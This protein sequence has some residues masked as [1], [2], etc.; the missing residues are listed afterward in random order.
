MGRTNNPKKFD[1]QNRNREKRYKLSENSIIQAHRY[2][3]FNTV[4]LNTQKEDHLNMVKRKARGTKLARQPC[5]LYKRHCEKFSEWFKDMAKRNK[6]RKMAVVS[7]SRTPN[8]SGANNDSS[9][10]QGEEA[11]NTQ[12][13]RP[14]QNGN[15]V[16][17]SGPERD[18]ALQG[19][20]KKVRGPTVLD[21][22][23]NMKKDDYAIVQLNGYGLPNDD[24]GQKYCQFLGTVARR[25]TL[26]PID[27]FDWRL[28]PQE[29]KDKIWEQTIMPRFSF[30]PAEHAKAIKAWTLEDIGNKWRNWKYHLRQTYLDL[31]KSEDE[32]IREAEKGE[33]KRINVNQ[34]RNL[35]RHWLTPKAQKASDTNKVC[36]SGNKDPH[37]AGS[38][39]FS[40]L[41]EDM[42]KKNNG[43]MPT[44]S[45]MYVVTRKH[46]D[47]NYVNK[48]AEDF[49]TSFEG[50]IAEEEAEQERQERELEENPDQ[51]F[52]TTVLTFI[53]RPWEGQGDGYTRVK[54]KDPKG[55][56][57]IVGN[58]ASEVRKPRGAAQPHSS[59][60]AAM[61][62]KIEE[63]AIEIERMN[64]K[65]EEQA[66]KIDG[67]AA[68]IEKL[69]QLF[70]DFSSHRN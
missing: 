1:L 48:V 60:Q 64:Q 11:D 54:G 32:M 23:W 21:H 61:A 37:C 2:I 38:M 14:A 3:L 55:R 13:T 8:D 20:P 26:C 49:G 69:K 65:H 39:S 5:D 53:D 47:G 70:V 15:E 56:T 18:G 62:L 68:E 35:V 45:K 67:Q 44:R 33:K 66:E 58:I 19:T 6:K 51:T 22:I 31:S 41:A 63:Q 9:S 16:S 28:F 36:R 25:P 7:R 30:E 42:A 43:V 57:N 27:I 40:R 17:S 50:V 12:S 59:S 34:F 46:S 52:D 24:N 10:T 29:S 4:E